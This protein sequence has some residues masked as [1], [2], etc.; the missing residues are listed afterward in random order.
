MLMF[1][2]ADYARKLR[3]EL[4]P[5]IYATSAASYRGLAY[6]GKNQ[7]ILVSGESG[8][9]K[10]ETVKLLMSHCALT[11]SNE[12]DIVIDKLLKANPL[13]ESFGNAKTSRNDN[14]SRFGKFSQ[15]EFDNLNHLVGSRC[16]TYLLEK[17]RVVT[18]NNAERNYH[19]FYQLLASPEHI[20]RELHL[21][22]KTCVDFQ[23]CNRGD[24][25][26]HVI[27]GI[28]DQDRFHL[29]SEAL[30]LLGVNELLRIELFKALAGILYLGQVQIVALQGDTDTATISR[31]SPE[32]AHAVEICAN[33]LGVDVEAFVSAVTCRT[34]G[35]EGQ[36]LTVPLTLAQSISGKDALAK[37]IYARIFQ[38]LVYVI[39]FNTSFNL[40]S[41]S[42]N[43]LVGT[44]SLLDIFGFECFTVNRFEQLCINYANEKLQQKFTQ[45]VFK[46]VQVEYQDEGLLWDHITYNDNVEILEL[47][48][49]KRGV[50][51]ALNEEC[52]VPRGSDSGLVSKLKSTFNQSNIFGVIQTQREQFT[53]Q[54]F[55]GK[56]AYTV[57]GFLERNKD[58]LPEDMRTLLSNS[59]RKLLSRVFT[60]SNVFSSHSSEQEDIFA[61][62][63]SALNERLLL[64]V[65]D[66]GGGYRSPAS[67]MPQSGASTAADPK[68][69]RSSFVTAETVTMKFKTQLSRL[70]E[71]ISATEV[72]YVRCIKPNAN[73]SAVEFSRQLVVEQLRTAGMIQAIQISRSAY[74][75]RLSYPQFVARFRCMRPRR[76]HEDLEARMPKVAA[77]AT[78]A[79][80]DALVEVRY[81]QIAAALI[82]SILTDWHERPVL[83]NDEIAIRYSQFGKTKVYFS[84]IFS[85]RMEERRTKVLYNFAIDIQRVARS[86]PIR[87]YFLLIRRASVKVQ[88]FWRAQ[89]QRNRYLKMKS[90]TILLQCAMRVFRARRVVKQLRIF[91]AASKIQAIVRRNKQQRQFKAMKY[92]ATVATSIAKM[93]SQRK[94]YIILRDLHRV[95]KELK[96]R[97][98]DIL[99]RF[100]FFKIFLLTNYYL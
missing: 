86:R 43:A 71:V 50:I 94:R 76:W 81:R 87:R 18:Q 72:Q 45:D 12:G 54:H 36:R 57:T 98:S 38:W 35:V 2:R 31:D 83:M 41:H 56:V 22:G 58:T 30:T 100:P 42:K 33:L 24:N 91:R 82:E 11:A 90:S 14:S 64:L 68:T 84:S 29:T 46:T 9:G 4:P 65:E 66:D 51:A 67:L 70:M 5:H 60:E 62:A 20:S 93:K 89:S 97:L 37:E 74:P 28:S 63:N 7:S 96:S 34:I 59:R 75:N 48:E 26:T 55:A 25:I 79:E 99:V 16:I 44:I 95:I 3:S 61:S 53:I 10:T 32:C 21:L 6:R 8:A 27:E 49:G 47:L 19:I 1:I 88:T 39:N 80:H 77:S 78:H 13:L 73:K 40:S 15:L 69:K 17:S 85:E 23:Y 92:V 52:I